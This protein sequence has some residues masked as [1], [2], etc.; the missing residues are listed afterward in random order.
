MT[1]LDSILKSRDITLPKKVRLVQAM[2]FPVVMYGCKSWTIR[3]VECPRIDAFEP[4]CWR[5]LLRVL[6]TARI[7]PVHPKW[8]Q[9]WLF[10]GRT[11]AEAETPILMATWC[12]ELTHLKIPWFWERLK[13]GGDVD[14][15]G[16]DGWMASPT[17][18]TWIW[19][20]SGSWWYMGKPCVLQSM[21]SQ[22]FG[23]DWRDLAHMTIEVL[24]SGCH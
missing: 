13:A 10:I 5:R 18:W 16:W 9:S 15:R 2:V 22:R 6:W 17:W 12:K 19:A 21:G 23:H 24:I 20:S 1:N 11:D 14:S 8:I 4:W 7:Q 3:K